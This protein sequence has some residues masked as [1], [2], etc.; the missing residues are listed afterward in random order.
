[1]HELTKT[2]KKVLIFCLFVCITTSKLLNFEWF[3]ISCMRMREMSRL[4][5]RRQAGCRQALPMQ[6]SNPMVG[7]EDYCATDPT[8]GMKLWK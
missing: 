3:E 8:L 4:P 1:M 7:L 6:I 5:V 2:G